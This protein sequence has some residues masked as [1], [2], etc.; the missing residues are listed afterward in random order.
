MTA[1]E[2]GARTYLRAAK[3]A[4]RSS[5]VPAYP[6]GDVLHLA[7]WTPAAAPGLGN[8]LPLC[9]ARLQAVRWTGPWADGWDRHAHHPLCSHCA[10]ALDNL[11]RDADAQRR[12]M[13]DHLD[14]TD[15]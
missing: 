11:T 4:P 2:E 13:A 15:R 9:G 8:L 3:P 7:A 5:R 1:Q 12:R 6:T 14:G 10:R